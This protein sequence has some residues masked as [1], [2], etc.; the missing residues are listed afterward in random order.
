VVRAQVR[1]EFARD[2]RERLRGRE[3]TGDE[4]RHPPERRVRLLEPLQ[5]GPI[6]ERPSERRYG[7]RDVGT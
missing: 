7:L 6:D 1:A 3:P 5:F 2:R 4:H